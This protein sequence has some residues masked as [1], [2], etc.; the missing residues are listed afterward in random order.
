MV[1]FDIPSHPLEPYLY[2]RVSVSHLIRQ[3]NPSRVIKSAVIQRNR[4]HSLTKSSN[5]NRVP[6]NSRSFFRMTVIREPM[7][8][9][10]NSVD[11][12]RAGD[13]SRALLNDMGVYFYREEEF[14][15]PCRF[16]GQEGK[17]KVGLLRRAP[18]VNVAIPMLRDIQHFPLF[19]VIG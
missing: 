15:K 18:W 1:V 12:V 4:I 11:E 2:A 17:G 14:G 13:V 19:T 7:H 6:V 10:I 16:E 5:P 8:L 3:K 9:S